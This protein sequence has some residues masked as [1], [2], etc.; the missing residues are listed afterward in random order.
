[1]E[2]SNNVKYV[3][4]ND[5]ITD[6]F[7]SQYRIPNGISYNSY[8]IKDEKTAIMDSVD[9]RFA[10]EWLSNIEKAMDGANPDYLIVQHMEPDHSAS[11]VRFADKYPNALIVSSAKA[12][13]MMANFFGCDFSDRRVVVTDGTILSLGSCDLSFITAPMVHWPE[14]IMTYDARDKV[15]F[16]ADAFGK[17]GTPECDDGWV[18]EAR[19]YYIGI[20]GKYGAQVQNVLKKAKSLDI[21]TICPLHGPVLSED[22]AKYISLY[23][24]WSSYT[25]EER[26]VTIACS[27]IYGNTMVAARELE[28]L[29]RER[30]L[31]SVSLFDLAR[32]DKSEAIASAFRYSHLVLASATYNGD[33]FPDMRAFISG[34][35]ERGFSGRTV[36]IIENGSWAPMAAKV[37]R[38][39]L[40]GS[41]NITYTENS[42]KILSAL[43]GESRHS[44]AL[45]ADELVKGE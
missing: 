23:D 35:V 20:V 37:I 36:G 16:S 26:G 12:F 38:A 30:G 21:S 2:I 4:V 10:D 45:L 18:D 24:K 3:G 6:L 44:L 28:S 8:V 25:P 32:C 7:E 19:R 42:V 15:L 11:V 27:S 31:E 9:I 5:R 14:V 43:N 29:L 41:K 40:E 34:L 22:L 39:S 17:F 13:V 1:M 33:V